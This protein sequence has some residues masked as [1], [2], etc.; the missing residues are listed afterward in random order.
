MIIHKETIDFIKK[1]RIDAEISQKEFADMLG[2]SSQF[3][4]TIEKHKANYPKV[5]MIAIFKNLNMS[6]KEI[7]KC[8]DLIVLDLERDIRNQLK[9]SGILKK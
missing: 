4:S 8:V 9:F 3:I 1:I 6:A 5:A 2:V 7:K